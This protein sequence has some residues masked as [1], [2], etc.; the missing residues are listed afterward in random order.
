M[1]ERHWWKTAFNEAYLAAFDDIYSVQRGEKE[2]AFLVRTL[3]MKKGTR[4]LDL[5][6]GQ[7]RHVIPLAQHEMRVTGVDAS[8]SLL[9][10]AR[11]RARAR[12]VRASFMKGDMRTFCDDGQYDVVLVLGNSFGYFSDKDNERVLSAIA[13]SLKNGGW[14]VLD[15]SNT[16]GMLRRQMTGKWTQKI[17]G[18]TLTTRTLGFNPETFQATMQWHIVQ[19]KRETSFNGIFRF[20]TPP[21][22]NRLL[23]ERNLAIK[24]TYGSFTNEAFSIKAERYLVMAR[25]ISDRGI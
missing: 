9:R 3:R 25:K 2:V 4:V 22:M 10:E 6:C 14:L 8:V 16:A 13:T 7:G 5:A 21:E 20:Y 18:G 24:K 23:I 19:H 17:P 12:G 11:Q 1:K 15:L